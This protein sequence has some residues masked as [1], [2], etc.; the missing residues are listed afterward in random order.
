MEKFDTYTKHTSGPRCYRV[1]APFELVI[2]RDELDL[3]L[4]GVGLARPQ[5]ST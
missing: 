3:G 5:E 1:P 2:K 4:R